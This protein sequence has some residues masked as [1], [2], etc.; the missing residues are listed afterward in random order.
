LGV[1]TPASERPTVEGDILAILQG[2]EGAMP[3]EPGLYEITAATLPSGPLVLGNEVSAQEPL[4]WDVNL[5]DSS[6]FQYGTGLDAVVLRRALNPV[7]QGT[8]L[9]TFGAGPTQDEAESLAA[10]FVS[11]GVAIDDHLVIESGANAGN[12][13]RLVSMVVLS[14]PRDY[15]SVGAPQIQETRIRVVNLDGSAATLLV[16]AGQRYRII[17]PAFTKTRIERAKILQS[18]GNM[19]AEVLDYDGASAIPFDVFTPGM[20]GQD[21]NAQNADNPA[22]DGDYVIQAYV[23]AGR[24]QI[25]VGAPQTSDVNATGILTLGHIQTATSRQIGLHPGFEKAEEL[26]PLDN[27]EVE[28]V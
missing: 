15:T 19:F 17:R 1:A 26:A 6:L 7:V 4:T 28:V 18:G 23:H 20:V 12:E 13:Y 10:A 8:D 11:D 3:L 22:N 21:L 16:G 24:V 2:Q 27:F 9:Q 5:P 14:V 25:T